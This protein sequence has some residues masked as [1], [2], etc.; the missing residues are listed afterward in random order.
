VMFAPAFTMG[1]RKIRTFMVSI[2]GAQLG[3]F[4]VAAQT[5]R[6]SLARSAVDSTYTALGSRLSGLKVPVPFV[7]HKTPPAWVKTAFRWHWS[8]LGKYLHL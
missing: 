2:A 8:L 3:E 7:L 5:N 6:L 1:A 4:R